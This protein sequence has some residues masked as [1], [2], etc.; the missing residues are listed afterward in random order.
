MLCKHVFITWTMTTKILLF[1][2]ILICFCFKS[3][4]INVKPLKIIIIEN[5]F[6]TLR[7]VDLLHDYQEFFTLIFVLAINI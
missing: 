6:T 7:F 3:N 5:N 4:Y 2:K 1:A